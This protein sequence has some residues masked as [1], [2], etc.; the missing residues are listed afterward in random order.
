MGCIAILGGTGPEGVGLG[1]R[2]ALVGEEVMRL[3]GEP[4]QQHI[5]LC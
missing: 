3:L 1:L 4:Q 5:V 2:F